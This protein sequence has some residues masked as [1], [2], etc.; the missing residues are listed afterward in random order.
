MRATACRHPRPAPVRPRPPP[1]HAADATLATSRPVRRTKARASKVLGADEAA[2][3][4]A[5]AAGKRP[6]ARRGPRTGPSR[7]REYR[8]SSTDHEDI[9]RTLFVVGPRHA[10]P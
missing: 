3:T 2:A 1:R 10:P 7:L 5:G 6:S 9:M 8:K 4:P